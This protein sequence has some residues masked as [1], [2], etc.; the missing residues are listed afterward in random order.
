MRCNIGKQRGDASMRTQY[1]YSV[2]LKEN[3]AGDVYATVLRD[4]EPVLTTLWLGESNEQ[5]ISMA[6]E[7]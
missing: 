3:G 4:G 6:G 1:N 7:L 2:I 5:L